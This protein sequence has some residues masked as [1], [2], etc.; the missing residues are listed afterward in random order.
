[1]KVGEIKVL[2]ITNMKE[3]ENDNIEMNECLTTIGEWTGVDTKFPK[4]N[5][6]KLNYESRDW[7]YF[8]YQAQ[9][10]THTIYRR[11]P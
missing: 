4:K 3:T 2:D 9:S 10:G 1:M 11:K 5:L 7:E 6:V 8:I